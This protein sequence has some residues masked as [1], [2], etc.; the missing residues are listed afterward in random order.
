MRRVYPRVDYTQ[1]PWT[2]VRSAAE[3]KHLHFKG[4]TGVLSAIP[5]SVGLFVELLS[6]L[7]TQQK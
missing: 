1:A 2:V 6:L 3:P 5:H 7:A 4:G